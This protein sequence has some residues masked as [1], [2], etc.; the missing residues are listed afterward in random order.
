MFSESSFCRLQKEY[1]FQIAILELLR[2]NNLQLSGD[3]RCDIQGIVLNIVHTNLWTQPLN[4]YYK[5]I[6]P[7]ETGCS[8]AKEES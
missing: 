5:L 7:S 3:G 8:V 4:L 1:L 6:Q 2:A